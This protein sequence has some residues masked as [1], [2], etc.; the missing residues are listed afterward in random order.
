MLLY[1]ISVTVWS[2]VVVS[3]EGIMHIDLRRAQ[4]MTRGIQKPSS[5][6]GR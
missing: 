4:H 3:R 1:L 6:V 5:P 2:L